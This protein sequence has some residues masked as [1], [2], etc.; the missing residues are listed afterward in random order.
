MLIYLYNALQ[1]KLQGWNQ[2][3]TFLIST[4]RTRGLRTGWSNITLS[5]G[6]TSWLK[7]ICIYI[8]GPSPRKTEKFPQMCREKVRWAVNLFTSHCLNKHLESGKD[9]P[10][11]TWWPLIVA[12]LQRLRCLL[13]KRVLKLLFTGRIHRKKKRR[14]SNWVQSKT[15]R[16]DW[17]LWKRIWNHW[18]YKNRESTRPEEYE[19]LE[20]NERIIKLK[21]YDY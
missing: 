1:D 21:C 12:K 7:Q 20:H 11:K 4:S 16:N 15:E 14:R 10:R 9:E 6:G 2:H 13:N 18:K 19:K 17:K 5:T 3:V 8:E